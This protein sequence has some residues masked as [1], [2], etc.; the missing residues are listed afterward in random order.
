MWRLYRCLLILMLMMNCSAL[1]AFEC[2]PNQ[3]KCANGRCVAL[4][5]VCDNF[6]DCGDGTDELPENCDSRKCLDTEFDCGAPHNQC[7]PKSWHCDGTA[8]CLNGTDEENCMA[9][10]CAPGQ[11]R[12]KTGH[13]ISKLWVCDNMKDCPDGSDEATCPKPTCSPQQFQCRNNSMCVS[14]SSRCDGELDCSDG[15]DESTETCGENHL[16][17]CRADQFQCANGQCI[18]GTWRCDGDTDCNDKSDEDSCSHPTCRPDEFQCGNGTCI[19]GSHQCDKVHDCA[20]SSD[21]M[22]CQTENACDGPTVFKC[23][24]GKCISMTKVCDKQQDCHDGSDEPVG[25][26]D[27]NE[28]LVGNVGCS[29]DCVDH[30]LGYTCSC[31][32]GYTL[33]DDK[34]CE[35]IDECLQP[36]ICSQIC[37][38]EPGS[39]RCDCKDGYKMDPAT[40]TCKAVAGTTPELYF[41]NRHDVRKVTVDRSD[42]VHVMEDLKDAVAL[43]IDIPNKI[44]FWSDLFFKKIYSSKLDMADQSSAHTVV[45]G[46][47]VEAPEG[48]AVDWIHGNIYWTDSFLKT[49]SVATMDGSKRKTLIADNLDEPRAI[50]VDPMNNFMYWTD[51]GKEAK[52]EKSGLNGADRVTLVTDNILWPNGITLDIVNQRLYWVDSKLHTLSSVDVNGG[53]RNTVIYSKEKLEHPLS[54]AVFEDEVFW[55]DMGNRAVFGA[56]R[57]TGENIKELASDLDHPEDIVVYHNLKQP[58]GT[59]WCT[60]GNINGG[61]EYLCLPAPVIN[62]HSPKYTCACPDHMN[63]ASDMRKCVAK[64]TETNMTSSILPSQE[65][66]LSDRQQPLAPSPA[67]T[68]DAG[69]TTAVYVAIPLVMILLVFGLVLV[70][71]QWRMKNT[72]TMHF[73]NPVY[74]K[75]TEDEVQICNNSEGYV[76]LQGQMMSMEDEDIA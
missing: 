42:Y 29:H 50:T 33:K 12:C 49:I 61:C 21:E 51:W 14:Y 16:K 32:A 75:T 25:L 72:N 65:P 63:M 35:D 22:D 2:S 1:T 3:L 11:F 24:S 31:P 57:K 13:C 34:N 15:S 43:D 17:P 6:N 73:V 19:H 58:N 76:H 20:D 7:V 54:L 68:Q 62:Q 38:N 67:S 37:I 5:W 48:L 53:T 10:E 44:I 39:Y 69:H 71:R 64:A 28:C 27:I 46:D 4:R 9:K 18:Y 41:A 60:E 40:T 36:D 8:D 45:I 56:D 26:C 55:T 47:K 74:Q 52:I 66:N 70:W 59:N 23:R 30:K